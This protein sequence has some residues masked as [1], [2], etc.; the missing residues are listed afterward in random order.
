MNEKQKTA[1]DRQNH[2]SMMIYRNYK[3]SIA[4]F[5]KVNN[6]GYV[7]IHLLND[8]L[9]LSITL[10]ISSKHCRSNIMLPIFNIN[11]KNSTQTMTGNRWST[12]LVVIRLWSTTLCANCEIRLNWATRFFW[13]GDYSS[14]FCSGHDP[15][16]NRRCRVWNFFKTSSRVQRFLQWKVSPTGKNWCS[17]YLLVHI[18]S[19]RQT[20]LSSS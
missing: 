12:A 6:S 15:Q 7:I 5:S 19:R 1:H 16:N 13:L 2:I 4:L 3:N 9:C 11:A 20:L 8:I 17:K 18:I 10:S 14:S